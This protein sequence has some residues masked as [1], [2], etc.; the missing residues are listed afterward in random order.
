M[1]KRNNTTASL[2]GPPVLLENYF[3]DNIKS[4]DTC[5]RDSGSLSG[6]L[7]HPN[8]LWRYC[9]QRNKNFA[10]SLKQKWNRTRHGLT[11]TRGEEVLIIDDR[12]RSRT[13]TA[14]MDPCNPVS[15]P[16][17]LSRLPAH[18]L[19]ARSLSR[20]RLRNKR[21]RLIK[22][23]KSHQSLR[24][25]ISI[26][27]FSKLKSS[28]GRRSFSSV[29]EHEDA[30]KRNGCLNEA[31]VPEG[32][33]TP[34]AAAQ[35]SDQSGSQPTT[36]QGSRR[37]NT[38]NFKRRK[39]VPDDYSDGEDG[40]VGNAVRSAARSSSSKE[41]ACPFFKAYP[42]L[43][44]NCRDSGWI[45]RRKVKDH[46]KRY[47]YNGNAPSEIQH[48]HAWENWYRYIVR[49]TDRETRAIP[50]SDPN[51][52]K[53]LSYL[54][55][56]SEQLEGQEAPCFGTRMLK[57][58]QH[59]QRNPTE[60]EYI[61]R[62]IAAILDRPYEPISF[63]VDPTLPE[64]AAVPPSFQAHLNNPE[65]QFSSENVYPP[66]Q[67]PD[68]NE[69]TG[70]STSTHLDSTI[71][72]PAHTT[73]FDD[74]NPQY[75]VLTAAPANNEPRQ[76]AEVWQLT[77]IVAHSI[78]ESNGDIDEWVRSGD[79]EFNP[80]SFNA[81]MDELIISHDVVC[82][83]I[84]LHDHESEIIS[85][86]PPTGFSLQDLGIS[87]PASE[88][89]VDP[90]QMQVSK[91]DTSHHTS[92]HS[93]TPLGALS[94]NHFFAKMAPTG[95]TMPAPAFLQPQRRLKDGLSATKRKRPR[96][97]SVGNIMIPSYDSRFSALPT[98]SPS[99]LSKAGSSL[100][101]PS[102]LTPFTANTT[103]S[104]NSFTVSTHIILVISDRRP[105]MF[106][107][108]GSISNAI[109]AFVD[110]ISLTF[111]FE[112]TDFTREF[113]FMNDNLPLYN[114]KAVL[115]QLEDFWDESGDM[116]FNKAIPWF[117]IDQR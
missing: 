103:C 66:L 23:E 63:E 32:R 90:K 113:W 93:S 7:D 62:G 26:P 81:A 16:A 109:D 4:G 45:E 116:F 56:V 21:Q 50:N 57:L 20:L 74:S 46:L 83:E 70:P 84:Q 102:L 92:E 53:I 98:P 86:G 44:M 117:W 43:H 85:S 54:L 37:R 87:I 47:H 10:P 39:R 71:P 72:D 73:D 96:A 101:T 95:D 33:P 42:S 14:L 61:I 111:G 65:L 104:N 28:V 107:F 11:K 58:F 15:G 77:P 18:R 41:Y 24:R 78:T 79:H 75:L 88:G 106:K 12:S 110:W 64:I 108:S 19:R 69:G 6:F 36:P 1:G 9:S 99:V 30:N 48:S 100:M 82:Q 60:T 52:V 51:F 89:F 55:R 76:G 3:G 68:A 2:V 91:I 31:D 40:D 17:G 49:D 80:T 114:K 25:I 105:E 27:K 22:K 38:Q 115:A 5:A 34:T 8:S 94:P 59:A 35:I 13:Q 97:E 29:D 112:F 67:W